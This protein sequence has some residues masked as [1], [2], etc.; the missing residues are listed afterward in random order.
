M[1]TFYEMTALV[2]AAALWRARIRISNLSSAAVTAYLGML[3][4]LCRSLGALIYGIVLVPLVLF[5]KPRVQARFAVGL[6]FLALSYP[7]LRAAGLFPTQTLVEFAA[8]IS[9][10]RSRSIRFSL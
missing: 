5:T 6:V 9:D 1:L 3:L 8:K 7:T 10:E 2:A 4:S